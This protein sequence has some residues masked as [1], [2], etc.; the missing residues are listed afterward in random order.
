LVKA[1]WRKMESD[2]EMTTPSYGIIVGR[3]QVHELHD[4][5]MEL[6]RTVRGMHNRVVVF[7][8]V[9]PIPPSLRNPLDFITRKRM[10]E[11]AFPDVT[12]VALPDRASDEVW[13]HQLDERI[14]EICQW[15]S[16]TL[17]GGRDCFASCYNGEFEVQELPLE[18]NRSGE[19][20]RVQVSNQ[21]LASPDFRAG[22]IYTTQNRPPIVYPCVDIAVIDW[23]VGSGNPNDIK[24]LLGKKPFEAK[25]RL[26]GGHVNKG[27]TLEKAAQRELSEETGILND[28]N[29]FNYVGSFP[30]ED[31]RYRREAD[32]ITSALFYTLY[33]MGA[34][35]AADDLAE[36][37]WKPLHSLAD[38]H[39]V[40]AHVPLIQA[41]KRKFNA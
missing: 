2:L 3:F 5:H 10:I 22:V 28:S 34:P 35:R 27:E 37:S 29:T 4:G 21:V 41:L 25:W 13:S 14:R 26:P 31:W 18:I 7:L 20:V 32:S 11:A 23:A 40:P 15:G 24:V 39:V 6:I 9:A 36:V 30:I 38:A 33:T 1:H 8:G 12:V 19:E 16:I 17:Y